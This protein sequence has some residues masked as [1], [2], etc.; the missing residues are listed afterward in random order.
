VSSQ[1]WRLTLTNKWR[2]TTSQALASL[3]FEMSA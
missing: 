2:P 3:F 1:N